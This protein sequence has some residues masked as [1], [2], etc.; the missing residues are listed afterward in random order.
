MPGQQLKARFLLMVDLATKLKA[1]A[2]LKTYP[3][4]SMQ[5]E[6]AAE[7]I[8]AFTTSWLGQYPRPSV[9]T[10]DNAKS[11][12]NPRFQQFLL[13][14]NIQ[15]HFPPEKE[16]WAH[17]I[18]E[19]AIGD[20]KHVATCIQLDNLD[21][22]PALS[23]A[24]AVS[25]LNA[26]EYTAGFSAHQWAFGK[27]YSISD[28]DVR[29]WHS[30]EPRADFV[31][32]AKARQQAEEIARRARA[33][34]VLG[35]LSNTT[36]KQPVRLYG[37]TEL[38]MVW[39]AVQS[40]EQHRGPRG[41]MKK[42][43]R[44]RWV[45]PGRVVFSET[46]PHQDD[47]DLRQ[48]ILWVL[49]GKRLLRC[50]VHSVR[51]ATESER[52]RHEMTSGE[53]PTRW[54]TLSD[55]IPRREYEDITSEEPA[56]DEVE[57]PDLPLE[58]DSTTEVPIRR[59]SGKQ[60]LQDTNK[61][62]R[63][64]P[65]VRGHR[66]SPIGLQRDH[67]TLERYMPPHPSAADL[68]DYDHDPPSD[69]DQSKDAEAPSSDPSSKKAR[70]AL[71]QSYDL[72]WLEQMTA[73]AQSEMDLYG[74]FEECVEREMKA[75]TIE[76][77]VDISSHRA[78]RDFLHNP[79]S[80]LV[81]KLNNSEVVL[82]NLS[83]SDKELFA[84]AKAKEVDSFLRNQAVRKCLSSEEVRRAFDSKRIVHARWVLTW[85]NIPPE[86]RDEILQEV[87]D[88]PGTTTARSDG[89]RKAKARIVLLGFQHPSLL[90]PRFK[91]SAPVISSMGRNLIY[92]LSAM[93]QWEL[94]GLDLATAFLQTQPT[95][96]DAEI[97]TTGVRE[98]REAL[99][100]SD[101]EVMRI[102]R[103]VYGST[104]APRGLWL[105]LNNTLGEK[106][107]RVARGERC[108]WMWH[109]KTEKDASGK[110]PR[111]IGVMG[112]H[113]DDFHRCGD[114]N[115]SEWLAIRAEID[116][117]YKWG[118]AR[119]GSY[120]HAG[121][122]VHTVRQTDGRFKIVVEQNAYIETLTDVDMSP[123]RLRSNG[124]LNRHEVAACRTTLGRLQWVAH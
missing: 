66:S 28:E 107:A 44:P 49:L 100:V 34:R 92:L 90:D 114:Q 124:P 50:S 9:V 60:P 26:T 6:S 57:V 70:L 2:V 102:L 18:V 115:S 108:L 30:V 3:E 11:F 33:S 79:T 47:Q 118:M 87:R 74:I 23:L 101:G 82:K 16:P 43:G 38:V 80:Y 85:K 22:S 15:P 1:V 106:G 59:V 73:D 72:K 97:W 91:T 88:K 29:V 40:A 109:S 68:N 25:S 54:K 122:D 37:P 77:D 32:V 105:S 116:A 111:L 98:L 78:R 110:F 75:M 58:P 94:E 31:N 7:I 39:R 56:D 13:D 12:S 120:R 71:L 76:V 41:G 51:P 14:Q 24:L 10:A 19:S 83:A 104:T 93:N 89:S 64:S 61:K 55:L 69:V 52:F 99:G 35:R 4:L 46:L 62:A 17:G 48:H 113:V 103:N 20:V 27:N 65:Y 5:S 117:A 84:R 63:F 95:E 42:A 45:G 53:D 8:E 119:K 123:E 21:N 121:C 96:A 112:G 67:P 86:E 36:V 81:K